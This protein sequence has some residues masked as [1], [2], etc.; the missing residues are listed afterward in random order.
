[1][2]VI[3]ASVLA[4]ALGD[5]GSLGAS[6]RKRLAGQPLAA[7]ELIYLEAASV[8]RRQVSLGAMTEERARGALTDLDDLPLTVASHTP[9]LTRCWQLRG[10]VS[11]YDA[12]YVALAEALRVPLLTLDARLSRSTGPRCVIELFNQ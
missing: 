6:V 11:V 10:N 3:D 4:T 1:M 8:W 12:A 7:P 2:L 9:L 5:D